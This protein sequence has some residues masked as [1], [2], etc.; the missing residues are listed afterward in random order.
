MLN[1][2]T[3]TCIWLVAGITD[4]RNSFQGLAAKIESTLQ[5]SPFSGHLFVFRGKQ[6]HL[7]KILWSTGDGLCLLSKR[8]EQGRFAWP[9]ARDG[10]VY[11]TAAQLAMLL[12]GLEWKQPKRSCSHLSVL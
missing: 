2:P 12:E 3:G 7:L 5:E 11:L 6:G 8:L 4:M 10:K 1:L 9:Q